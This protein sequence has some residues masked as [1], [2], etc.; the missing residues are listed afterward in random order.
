MP[1]FQIMRG[2]HS[3]GGKTYYPR[4][5]YLDKDGVQQ[6]EGV[7]GQDIIDSASDLSKHNSLGI[8]RFHPLPDLPKTGIQAETK[9]EEDGLDDLKVKQLRDHAEANGIDL[10]TATK[11]AEIVQIIRGEMQLA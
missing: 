3:E 2:I 8:E 11:H 9:P 5:F 10:G 7:E 6:Q 4:G 1:R